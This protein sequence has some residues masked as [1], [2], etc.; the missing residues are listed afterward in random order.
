MRFLLD[1]HL[2]LWVAGESYRLSTTARSLIEDRDNTLFFSVSSL[3]EIAI[4]AGSGRADFQI[5]AQQM[6]VHLLRHGYDELPILG[7]HVIGIKALPAI[8]R[9]PFD[10]ILVA[11]AMVE[12][13]TL[14]TVDRF[15]AQYPG[16]IQ[17]V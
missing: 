17:R 9:D 2:L 12:G 8:H 7:E 4:K 3:W 16:P 11:Q 14:L 1:T 6:R 5:D 10:R 15:L 13:L